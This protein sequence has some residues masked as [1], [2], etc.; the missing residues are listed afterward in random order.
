M[1]ILS[2]FCIYSEFLRYFFLI[3]LHHR[4]RQPYSR[5]STCCLII[6]TGPAPNVKCCP[7]L[8]I[9]LNINTINELQNY[10]NCGH[11]MSHFKAKMHQIRFRLGLRPIPSTGGAYSLTAYSL[12]LRGRKGGGKERTGMEQK[13]GEEKEEDGTMCCPISNKLSPPMAFTNSRPQVI[14]R[15]GSRSCR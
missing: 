15:G 4:R 12:F 1:T 9:G 11:Q 13:G 2:T 3:R 6:C 5:G 10:Y 14:C 7:I 8:G